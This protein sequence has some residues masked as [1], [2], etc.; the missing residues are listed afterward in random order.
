MSG[1]DAMALAVLLPLGAAVACLLAGPRFAR[2]VGLLGALATA[3]TAA[4]VAREVALRG[5]IRHAV[6]G[7]G[8]PLGI[9]LE[10][11]GLSALM[12]AMT[13]AV[14]FLISCYAHAYFRSGEARG[15]AFWFW[16]LW[17]FLWA[18]L[19]ALFLSADVFNFYV[20][21]ELGSL[22]AVGLVALSGKRVA[23]VA[24]TRYLFFAIVGSLLYLLGIALLYGQYG[25]LDMALLKAVAGNHDAT[26]AA[27]LCIV[28]G[29][30]LKTALVPLHIWL[31]P[32]HSSAPAPV[33]A[34]LSALV[35]KGS[36]Y[37]LV[38]F[39]TD[40]LPAQVVAAPSYLLGSLGAIAIIWGSL[41]ALRQLRLKLVIAYSTVAQIGYLFILFPLIGAGSSAGVEW[42]AKAWSGG[43]YHA[44]SHAFAKAS[45]FLAAGAVMR[46]V[47]HDRL[48]ALRGLGERMPATLTAMALASITIMGLPPGGGFI[49]K[50][51][52]LVAALR[53]G[54]W[55]WVATLL[56]GGLLAAAYSF[57]MLKSAFRPA[58]TST[59]VQ[60]VPAALEWTALALAAVALLL[61]LLAV[62]PLG[63]LRIGA[64]FPTNTFMDAL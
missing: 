21:L 61:G 52:L 29:L 63:L 24:A 19:H 11:D 4:W 25:V 45:L 16:P 64:P 46:A 37:I 15:A 59:P 9:E 41:Q 34:A 35:V 10:A 7:W 62:Y 31:P 50:W 47:G 18:A 28:A 42:A 49:G 54:Q 36:F 3:A 27:Y 40:V 17:F 26:R 13:S 38:R 14:S 23:V 22:S 57:R 53:E 20:A 2:Q 60:P 43:I 33:S 12:L 1:H 39:H 8:S 48:D 44:L 58:E 51:L 55:F 56:A 32:A 6:G 30:V 5:V